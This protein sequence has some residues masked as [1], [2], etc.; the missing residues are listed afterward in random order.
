MPQL[1]KAKPTNGWSDSLSSRDRLGG[2]QSFVYGFEYLRRAGTPVKRPTF[3]YLDRRVLRLKLEAVAEPQSLL[4]SADY[5]ELVLAGDPDFFTTEQ[6]HRSC[7]Q[8]LKE[9][10]RPTD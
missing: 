7:H 3:A 1:T 9:R 2:F 5:T 4:K 10:Q 8:A 6:H